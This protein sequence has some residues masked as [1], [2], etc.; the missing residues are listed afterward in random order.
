LD[1]GC[2]FPV[3]AFARV[4]GDNLDISGFVASEDG[5]NILLEKM[6]SEVQDAEYAGKTLAEKLLDRGAKSLLDTFS[7]INTE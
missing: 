6:R 1:S 2:Q 5:T 3:G 7:K 4:S